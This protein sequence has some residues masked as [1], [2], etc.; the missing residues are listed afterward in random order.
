MSEEEEIELTDQSTA[1]QWLNDDEIAQI[2]LQ[3]ISNSFQFNRVSSNEILYEKKQKC[4]MIGKYV[5]GDKLGEGSYAKV[6]EVLDSESLTRRA[7]KV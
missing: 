6:K 4:K 3:T 7:V 1:V 5:M 2:D